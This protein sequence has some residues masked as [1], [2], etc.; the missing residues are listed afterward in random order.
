MVTDLRK[1]KLL[2]IERQIYN[3]SDYWQKFVDAFFSN[4]V[5]MGSRE[6]VEDG[7]FILMS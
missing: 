1:M 6:H 7:D 4:H 3:L 2:F 5:E